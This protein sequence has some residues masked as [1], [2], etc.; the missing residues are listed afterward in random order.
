MA[1][2]IL[3]FSGPYTALV[4]QAIV[5]QGR[6]GSGN[7]FFVFFCHFLGCGF[8]ELQT[9]LRGVYP[10]WLLS[11][12]S[13]VGSQPESPWP[14]GPSRG[15]LESLS[16]CCHFQ[17]VIAKDFLSWD[18]RRAVCTQLVRLYLVFLKRP[19]DT[20]RARDV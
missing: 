2:G 17:T 6:P 10:Q 19:V 8:E 16:E 4:C 9:L 1:N 12:L 15:L 7:V 11:V 20:P 3:F 13:L 18:V 5:S 14:D